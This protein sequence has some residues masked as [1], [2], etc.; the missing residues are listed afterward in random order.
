[1]NANQNLNKTINVFGFSICG[2]DGFQSVMAY[3]TSTTKRMNS[4]IN[5]IDKELK[6]RSTDLSS[7]VNEATRTAGLKINQDKLQA[8]NF[9]LM[10]LKT[11]KDQYTIQSDDAIL[12]ANDVPISCIDTE[13][14]FETSENIYKTNVDTFIEKAKQIDIALDRRIAERMKDQKASIYES[15][16]YLYLCHGSF[17][18]DKDKPYPI[19]MSDAIVNKVGNGDYVTA[20]R[21]LCLRALRAAKNFRLTDYL[22]ANTQE[23][24]N[25]IRDS[26]KLSDTLMDTVDDIVVVKS[27]ALTTQPRRSNAYESG[28]VVSQKYDYVRKMNATLAIERETNL[29]MLAVN[30]TSVNVSENQHGSYT[31]PNDD[32]DQPVK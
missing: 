4:A 24:R 5:Y 15:V 18:G 3:E 7:K 1:M 6:S 21:E 30:A 11:V 25:K 2:I 28:P 12:K 22:R 8:V 20:V 17:L 31:L 23:T 32:F 27:I 14:F 16:P 9:A 19:I 10:I 13:E 26:I 29:L